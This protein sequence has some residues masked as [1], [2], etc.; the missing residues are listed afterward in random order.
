V[1]LLEKLG[2]S[3]YDSWLTPIYRKAY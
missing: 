3:S 1:G 2:Q